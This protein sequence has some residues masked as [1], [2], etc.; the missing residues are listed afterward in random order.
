MRK[1][2]IMDVSIVIIT[3][4]CWHH[5][6]RCLHSVYGKVTGL[7]FEVIVIDNNSADDTL[8]GIKNGFPQVT[9]IE[10]PRNMGVARARNQG[11]RLARGRYVLILDADVEII[12]EDF[13][14]LVSYMDANPTVGI[15]GCTLMSEDGH[16]H[17]SARTFPRP[18]HVILRRLSYIGLVKNSR[19]LK[20]HHLD[21]WD[22]KE[23]RGVDMVEGAFQLIRKSV[24]DEIGPLD[25]HMFYGFEDSDYC[26]RAIKAGYE[27]VCFPGFA[28]IHFLQGITRGNPFN[29]MAFE[30]FRSYVRFYRKHRELILNR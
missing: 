1:P 10:N 11:I 28:G 12:S 25:E 2:D 20:H 7:G 5:L 17:P 13:T 18:I 29:R 30:H 24:I 14:S 3:Y 27:V 4:N 21:D 23:P 22:R 19:I 26:A 9:L 16:V 8:E 6:E 15:M